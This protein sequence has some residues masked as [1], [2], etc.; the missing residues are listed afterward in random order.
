MDTTDS[1]YIGN[2]QA[3]IVFL[4]FKLQIF[5]YLTVFITSNLQHSIHCESL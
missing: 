3:N 2:T 4:V 1:P 5:K